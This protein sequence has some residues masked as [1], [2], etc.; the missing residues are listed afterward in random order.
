MHFYSTAK[1][2]PDAATHDA[3]TTLYY[4]TPEDCI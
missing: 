3:F 1:T 2:L 4:K